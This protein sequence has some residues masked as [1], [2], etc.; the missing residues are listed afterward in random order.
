MATQIVVASSRSGL[1]WIV[2]EDLL[3]M[4][5][6]KNGKVAPRWGITHLIGVAMALFT[7]F[8]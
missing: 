3:K 7:I 6:S 8:L 4:L 5:N 1:R 2:V